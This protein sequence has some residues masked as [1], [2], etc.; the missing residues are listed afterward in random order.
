MTISIAS[1]E[2][3]LRA[4]FALPE[5]MLYLDSAAHGP[6]LKAVRAAAMGVLQQSTTSWLG[7]VHWRNDVERVRSLAARLFDDNADAVAMVPSAAYGLSVAARNVPLQSKQS[8]LV[9]EGQFPSNLLPWRRRC[10]EVG[11]HLVFVRRRDGQDW[12]AAVL[13][14]LDEHP[15]IRVLA[16]PQAH[17]RDGGLLDLARIAQNARARG[18]TLVLDLSQSLGVLPVDMEAWQPDFVVAVGYKWLLGGYGLA[19]LWAAPQWRDQGL[20]LEDGWM[21]YDRDALWIAGS[22][23][24]V[25]P[26]PGARRYDAGGVCD[27]LRLSMAEAALQQVLDWGVAEIGA[28]LQHRTAAMDDAL[29]MHGLGALRAHGHAPH[30]CGVNLP[31]QRTVA[32]A[33]TLSEA[34]IVCTVRN[35]CVRIAPHLHAGIQEMARPIKVIAAA[36]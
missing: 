21:A 25:P 29:E 24:D 19:W 9:L 13:D 6:P 14:T 22:G 26:L 3:S 33:R 36:L 35:D 4:L 23:G 27:A 5:D 17:W 12:T 32:V 18:A 8:V 28:Q 34:G 11:A 7:G 20:P 10:A 30:I 15:E 1:D 16:L 31:P 2:T